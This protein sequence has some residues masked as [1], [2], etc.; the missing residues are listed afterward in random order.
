MARSFAGI[1]FK[2][3]LREAVGFRNVG[4]GGGIRKA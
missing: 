2:F 3:I 4:I 1:A